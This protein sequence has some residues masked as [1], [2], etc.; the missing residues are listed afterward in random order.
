MT[1]S[2][3]FRLHAPPPCPE[4]PRASGSTAANGGPQYTFSEA[5]SFQV[6]CEAQDE[7]DSYWNALLGGGGDPARGQR[8]MQRMMT[9]AKIDLAALQSA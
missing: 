3:F 5:T 6:P 4:S 1:G 2:L 8:V 9:M 7:I